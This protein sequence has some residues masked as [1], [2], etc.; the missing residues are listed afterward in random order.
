MKE[1]QN[2]PGRMW[3]VIRSA[4]SPSTNHSSASPQSLKIGGITIG[5]NRLVAT[6]FNKFFCAIGANLAKNFVDIQLNSFSKYLQQR[7]S[8]SI[9]L[10]IPNPTEIENVVHSLNLHFSGLIL[11]FFIMNHF[12]VTWGFG[13]SGA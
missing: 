5:D 12:I 1:N 6:H 7:I 13:T 11:I 9:C 2:H 4:L 3:N 8:S 10:D